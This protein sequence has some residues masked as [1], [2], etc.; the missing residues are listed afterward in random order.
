MPAKRLAARRRGRGPRSEDDEDEI[1]RAAQTDSDLSMDDSDDESG[2]EDESEPVS[3]HPTPNTSHSP[4][5][6]DKPAAASFFTA[7]PAAWADMVE[8]GTEGLPVVNFSE[9]DGHLRIASPEPPPAQPAQPA[10]RPAAAPPRRPPG[11]SAR[12]AYQQRLDSDPAFVPVVGEFWGHDD[13]LLDKD[14]R[15]L[16]GWWRGR[17]QGRGRARGAFFMRGRGRGG[18][19]NGNA[20]PAPSEPPAPESPMDRTWTHDGFE[21]MRK[22]EEARRAAVPPPRGTAFR[23][24]GAAPTRPLGRPWFVMKP[25]LMWTKQHESFLFFDPALKT[26]PGQPAGL[27]VRLPGGSPNIVRAIPRVSRTTK[28]APKS[29]PEV[30]FVVRLPRSG[31]AK[32]PEVQA[33]SLAPPPTDPPIVVNL[34]PSTVAAATA[35]L[36][37]DAEGW[38]SPDAAAVALATVS[39]PPA[40][41]PLTLPGPQQPPTFYP[42]AAPPGLMGFPPAPGFSPFQAPQ[43]IPVAFSPPPQGFTPPPGFSTP[44]PPG[45]GTPPGFTAP[46]PPGVAVDQRGG[47]YELAS[48]RPV[49][50]FNGYH[51]PSPSISN[52]HNPAH[53]HSHS[54]SHSMSMSGA[55]AGTGAEPPLFSFA[56]PKT[57]VEIRNPDGSLGGRESAPR[58]PLSRNDSS[59][60]ENGFGKGKLRTGAAAFVPSHAGSGLG[61]G[62]YGS[63]DAHAMSPLQYDPQHQHQHQPPPGMYDAYGTYVAAPFYYPPPP[64]MPQQTTYYHHPPPPHHQHQH[65]PSMVAVNGV[66]GQADQQPQGA[67]YYA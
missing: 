34:G 11:Q 35:S 18:F 1:E 48:G 25:E 19:V 64:A 57:K 22:R 13:R 14:L 47:L 52:L 15:S 60:S 33:Q 59:S 30:T 23:G 46:L 65:T 7:T 61:S 66:N 49:M 36:K 54:H 45:F 10:S 41:P 40:G 43:P 62:Y 12:Q 5:E 37:P 58:S 55:G 3:R 8:D 56:R 50:L 32:E 20:N 51:S 26:R 38:V 4:E 16:S 31:K 44:P 53:N 63:F 24:R 28:P 9:F 2:S 6:K 29:S 21:E 17:W 39:S 27:R 67:V 42:F